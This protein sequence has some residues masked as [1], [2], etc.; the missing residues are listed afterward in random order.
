M[1]LFDTLEKVVIVLVIGEPWQWPCPPPKPWLIPGTIPQLAAWLLSAAIAFLI[2]VDDPE[3]ARKKKSNSTVQR[4][5]AFTSDDPH[6]FWSLASS[7]LE[8]FGFFFSTSVYLIDF[9]STF[10]M[11][12]CLFVFI[13]ILNWGFAGFRLYLVVVLS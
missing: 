6:I 4:L 13:R 9:F 10:R 8:L 12:V 5:S 7:V 11:F 3:R 2:G 1:S